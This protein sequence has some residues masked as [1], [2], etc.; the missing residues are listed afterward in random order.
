[1]ETK[2]ILDKFDVELLAKMADSLFEVWQE[3]KGTVDQDN[4]HYRIA[5]CLVQIIL[6]KTQAVLKLTEGVKYYSGSETLLQ[7]PTS[8]YVL[9][10]SIYEHYVIFHSLFV[11]EKEDDAREVLE[12]FWE[13]AGETN[14]INLKNLP[15]DFESDREK[16]CDY[17][18]RLESD[19]LKKIDKLHATNRVK[20]NLRSRV[21]SI[22]NR[23]NPIVFKKNNKGEIIEF[24]KFDWGE[25]AS[26]LFYNKLVLDLY[27]CLSVYSHPTYLEV[28]HFGQMF[29]N[30]ELLNSLLRGVISGCVIVL[31]FV[32]FDFSE[33]FESQ[34][35]IDLLPEEL[36][37]ILREEIDAL[38]TKVKSF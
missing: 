24:R 17:I 36:V 29:D 4:K 2:D 13:L 20:E 1:M 9:F 3:V 35:A 14:K 34:R 30:R 11:Q 37:E 5:Q 31:L 19:I 15:D 6:M 21:N 27:T 32:I 26:N 38:R 22:K 28:T 8:M 16:S 10:R 23:Y 25:Y 7:D 33:T 18:D 12:L